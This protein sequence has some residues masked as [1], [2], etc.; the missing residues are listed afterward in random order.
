MVNDIM[1]KQYSS[2]SMKAYRVKTSAMV[3]T[4]PTSIGYGGGNGQ[5]DEPKAA[6]TKGQSLWDTEW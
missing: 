6:E 1:K 2:P 3:C 4:S 5:E